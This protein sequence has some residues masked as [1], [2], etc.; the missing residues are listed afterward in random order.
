VCEK[1]P[2]TTGTMFNTQLTIGPDGQI[3]GKHQ[4]LVATVG[5][6]LV[7]TGGWGDTL[8]AYRAPFG[9]VSA[10]IC[11]ENSN[12]LATY[13]MMTM[14][15][16][17]HVAAWPAFLSPALSLADVIETVSRGLAYSMSCFVVNSTGVVDDATIEA[18]EPGSDERDFLEG[19]KGQGHASIIGPTGKVIAGPLAGGEGILYA[20]VDLNDVLIPK[21]IHDFSGH[22]NRSDIF[23][24]TVNTNV[25][26]TIS[27]AGTRVPDKPAAEAADQDPVG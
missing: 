5:E 12:P 8:K 7:H 17:V 16:V 1:R 23:S 20:D 24:L 9:V 4:K 15:P 18:Y 22:Y 6:R 14:S 19:I 27:F 3:L 11:G 2:G 10:L 13:T 25:P 21:V 26:P